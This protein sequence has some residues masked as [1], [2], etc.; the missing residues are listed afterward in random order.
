MT[1]GRRLAAN[2]S[3]H[4]LAC[5][6]SAGRS[7]PVQ[8]SSSHGSAGRRRSAQSSTLAASS[9]QACSARLSMLAASQAQKAICASLGPEPSA[10]QVTQTVP[11][12]CLSGNRF[13]HSHSRPFGR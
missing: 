3:D 4:S 10:S 2:D 6:P 1:P 5:P 11:R 12:A 13:S 8:V 9:G 7:A